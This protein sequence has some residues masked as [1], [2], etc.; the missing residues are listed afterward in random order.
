MVPGAERDKKLALIHGAR[1]RPREAARAGTAQLSAR[2]RGADRGYL[3]VL[4][5]DVYGLLS[6]RS[7]VLIRGAQE[8]GVLHLCGLNI[9]E[10][11][12]GFVDKFRMQQDVEHGHSLHF[13]A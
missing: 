7:G 8:A 1:K 5:G 10:I 6:D 2:V 12:P 13:S 3:V 11:I 9:I 4:L